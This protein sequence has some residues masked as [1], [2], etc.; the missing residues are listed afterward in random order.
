MLNSSPIE[1]LG[2][3]LSNATSA[4]AETTGAPLA[5]CAQSVLGMAAL[6]AQAH[7]D[8]K[9]PWGYEVKPLSL[10]LLTVGASGERKSSVDGLVSRPAMDAQKAQRR[11]F[12]ENMQGYEN[13]SLLY[14]KQYETTGKKLTNTQSINIKELHEEIIKECGQP[15]KRPIDPMRLVSDP[16]VE[17]LYMMLERSQPS[18]ALF[19]D[20]GGLLIGGHAMNADNVLK[21]F[22]RLCKLWDGAAFDRVRSGD[23]AGILYGRRLSMHLMAQPEVMSELLN[24]ALADGQGILARCLVA[25][26][27][28]T[29]GHREVVRDANTEEIKEITAFNQ[30]ITL[31]FETPP[32]TNKDDEQELDPITLVL[33]EGAK[34]TSQHFGQYLEDSMKPEHLFHEI[35]DRTSKGSGMACRIAGVLAVMDSGLDTRTIEVQHMTNACHLVEWYLK[36]ALRIRGVSIISQKDTD[37]NKLLKWLKDNNH[38]MFRSAQVLRSGP[39]VLRNK[40]R[41]QVA[42]GVLVESG[43][44]NSNPK[45]TEVDGVKAK[46][47][48]TVL[49]NE[50]AK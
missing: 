33:S 34:D 10:F 47:S 26:P 19:S 6:S 11:N 18:V 24:N 16:T 37:A 2:T 35:K 32:Q 3:L 4:I 41:L 46:T 1:H 49:H 44:L 17:G 30:A 43:Y 5:L 21:T 28:S 31:L 20:E 36:E 42:I 27:V 14:K 22:A 29:I 15:P 7:F 39:S 45:G 9:L 13:S 25:W 48:W 50:E 23:G 40:D 38:K 12:S 8:V